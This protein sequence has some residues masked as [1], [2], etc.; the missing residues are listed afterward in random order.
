MPSMKSYFNP[1]S[2]VPDTGRHRLPMPLMTSSTYTDEFRSLT[3]AGK[4]EFINGRLLQGQQQGFHSL[5]AGSERGTARFPP[6]DL[7]RNIPKSYNRLK[8]IQRRADD[9]TKRIQKLEK[10]IALLELKLGISYQSHIRRQTH[11]PAFSLSPYE[12][13]SQS[14]RLPA[15]REAA[16]N[17]ADLPMRKAPNKHQSRSCI[18]G[19]RSKMLSLSDMCTPPDE[20]HA[21]KTRKE[22]RVKKEDICK[23][24]KTCVEDT[25]STRDHPI[26]VE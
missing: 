5:I 11:G 26:V 14:I 25:G 1:L 9:K 24:A 4:A 22:T 20:F 16:P 19:R 10:R 15:I 13:E 3:D 18:E 2:I 6:N 7:T 8:T 23:P 12:N 17:R 21:A